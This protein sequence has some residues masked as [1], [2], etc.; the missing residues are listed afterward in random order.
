MRWSRRT[1]F[2]Q[3]KCP[4]RDDC[5]AKLTHSRSSG[6]RTSDLLRVRAALRPW[7]CFTRFRSCWVCAHS[8]V[9]DK[10]GARRQFAR[11]TSDAAPLYTLAQAKRPVAAQRHHYLTNSLALSLTEVDLSLVSTGALPD[12]AL[13]CEASV[14]ACL[15]A[16]GNFAPRHICAQARLLR[17]A[18]VQ[19]FAERC[20]KTAVRP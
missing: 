3:T 14:L 13:S 11:T 18:Q 15:R 17:T 16:A 9:V 4:G 6:V 7:R 10:L 19:R 2:G 1:R 12:C 8:C 20:S 5:G